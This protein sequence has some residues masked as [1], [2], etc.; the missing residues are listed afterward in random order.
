MGEW[1]KRLLPL[2]AVASLSGCLWGPG[3]F[4]SDLALNRDGRFVLDYRGEIVL[5]TARPPEAKA[6]WDSSKARCFTDGRTE[7]VEFPGSGEPPEGVRLCTP[8]E[9]AK[10]RKEFETQQ[11]ERAKRESEQAEQM[12]KMFGLPGTDDESNRAF[13]EKLRKYAGWRSVVYR[14]K[15]VFDVDYHFEGAL[16]QDFLFPAMPDSDL[17]MPFIVLRRRADGTVQVNAPGLT[18]GAGPFAA[19]AAAMG[20]QGAD[21][22]A[23]PSLARG[24]FT[25]AT[26]GEILT[27][28]SEDGP[29]APANGR[30]R[31]AWDVGPGSKTIPEALVR[32]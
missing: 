21:K 20:M 32:L 16:T 27:N 6:A 7:V 5:Q 10:L 22:D 17:I 18:G 3:R 11:A 4:A 30:R 2:A 25:I 24:R 31:V 1:L 12:A 26:D 15:G 9:V 8:P 28:N 29:S 19:R 14:G 23:P 13:A